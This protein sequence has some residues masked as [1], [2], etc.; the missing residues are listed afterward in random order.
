MS[1]HPRRQV[2][3]NV[4][5]TGT[6]TGRSRHP[7]RATTFDF[8]ANTAGGGGVNGTD[9]SIPGT[10]VF[11]LSGS[12]IVNTTNLTVGA[13]LACHRIGRQ[14]EHRHTDRY[15]DRPSPQPADDQP[16]TRWT[17]TPVQP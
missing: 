1:A 9:G 8:F 13:S 7:G 16:R 3:W 4:S 15:P 11:N 12:G 6:L 14:A 5:G 17:S 10:G 2:F